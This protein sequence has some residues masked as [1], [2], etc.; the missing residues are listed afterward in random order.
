MKTPCKLLLSPEFCGRLTNIWKI[1]T[2]SIMLMM[3]FYFAWIHDSKANTTKWNNTVIL[4]EYINF[5]DWYNRVVVSKFCIWLASVKSDKI[6]LKNDNLKKTFYAIHVRLMRSP[7][8][9]K[10]HFIFTSLL[11]CWILET[12]PNSVMFL[13]IGRILAL[14]SKFQTLI[15]PHKINC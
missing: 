5:V 6:R 4:K 2:S 8:V 11:F 1:I 3:N 9:S 14:I 12:N 7:L 15:G 10:N 13:F